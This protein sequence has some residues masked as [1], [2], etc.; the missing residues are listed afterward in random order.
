V[1]R[2]VVKTYFRSRSAEISS[3]ISSRKEVLEEK[4]DNA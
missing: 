3:E 2:E 4:E 1:E